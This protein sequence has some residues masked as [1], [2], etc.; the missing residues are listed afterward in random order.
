MFR[1]ISNLIVLQEKRAFHME[2]VILFAIFVAGMRLFMEMLLLG[3]HGR[4]ALGNMLIYV[5]WYIQCFFIFS[6][7]IL[8]F[9]PPPWQ[10]RVNVILIGLFFG[11]MPPIFDLMIA[12]W[13]NVIIGYEGFE[14]AY[15]LNFPEGWSWTMVTEPDKIAVGEGVVFWLVIFFSAVYMW[16]RTRSYTK[17]L[18]TLILSYGLAMWISAIMPTLVRYLIENLGAFY[19]MGTAL[20]F[21]QIVSTLVVYFLFFRLKLLIH[22]LRR[23]LHILPLISILFVGYAWVKPIELSVLWP[24]LL[25]VFCGVMTLVQNDYWD[26]LE[27]SGVASPIVEKYDLIFIQ[28][29]WMTMVA[30][31]F[32]ADS[33]LAT[34]LC[35]YGVASYLYNS[36]LYRGKKY[37]PA[38]IKL[39]GIAGGAA[40]AI[41]LIVAVQPQLIEAAQDPQLARR[42]VPGM[43]VF[44]IPWLYESDIVWASFLAFGGWSVLATL[45]DEK[46]VEIDSRVGSQTA[47]VLLSRRGWSIEK[48]STML[49]TIA[50]LCFL[51]GAGGLLALER[52]SAWVGIAMMLLG[53]SASFVRFRDRKRD[54]AFRLIMISAYLLFMAFTI[55]AA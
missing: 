50:F 6:I 37:F 33:P 16:L 22:I 53:A 28:I 18:A 11:F 30:T 55:S 23:S 47:F 25:I 21:G 24:A 20:V 36:P 15:I 12:G 9:S 49:R 46:D 29:M 54:F 34:L 8:F 48:T 39:E 27:E 13:G 35:I 52:V 44:P 31:L 7:P 19:F 3:F 26:H 43:G 2:T 17:T 45:K 10:K 41:G 40:F 5:T 38:N 14:Y 42:I 1:W 51:I 32:F 4:P